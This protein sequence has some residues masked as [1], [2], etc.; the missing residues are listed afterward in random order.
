[1][2]D[3]DDGEFKLKDFDGFAFYS[4]GRIRVQFEWDDEEKIEVNIFYEIG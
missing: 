3:G 1:L 2:G 4:S